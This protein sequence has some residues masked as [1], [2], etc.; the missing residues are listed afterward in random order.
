MPRGERIYNRPTVPD[1]GRVID[2]A[3]ALQVP[4]ATY[5]VLVRSDLCQVAPSTDDHIQPPRQ[6]IRNLSAI[7]RHL[8]QFSQAIDRTGRR[9]ESLM[10]EVGGMLTVCNRLRDSTRAMLQASIDSVGYAVKAEVP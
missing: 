1:R 2:R 9:P 5:P 8:H 10:K 4:P 3:A 7:G 6:E